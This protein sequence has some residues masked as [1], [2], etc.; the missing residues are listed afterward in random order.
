MHADV[1]RG[2]YFLII[3][4]PTCMSMHI[5]GCI[6][7]RFETHMRADAHRGM[8]FLA[9]RKP[10]CMS[11][12]IVVCLPLRLKTPCACG[13]TSRDVFSCDQNTHMHASAHR[14]VSFLTIESPICVWMHIVGCIFLRLE[15]PCACRCTVGC[16]FSR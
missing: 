6:F 7:L 5:T 16:T 9:I 13:C 4:K 14:S 11:M 12:H 15:N 8:S 3:R 10:T 1:H 2:V